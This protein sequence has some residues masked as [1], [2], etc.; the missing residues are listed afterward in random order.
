MDHHQF[1]QPLLPEVM[2]ESLR[3]IVVT[4]WRGKQ[5]SKALLKDGSVL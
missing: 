5:Q 2:T 3:L 1:Q 4:V